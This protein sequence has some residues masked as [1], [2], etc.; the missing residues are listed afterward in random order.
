MNNYFIYHLHSPY[1]N[2]IAGMDCLTPIHLYIEQAQKWGMKALAFSEHG[3]VYNW[4]A[5]KDAVEAAGLKY[6]HAIE[7][8][9]TESIDGEKVRDNY[10]CVLIAKNWDGVKEINLLS[11]RAF[12]RA[13]GHFYYDP[14][15]TFDELFGTSDNII[16]TTA[17]IAGALGA[18]AT[19]EAREKMLSF[20]IANKHR[21]YLEVQHHNC[22][23]Q[24]DYNKT[25]LALHREFG[26]PLIA[27]TD[28]H[29]LNAEYAQARLI[30]EHGAGKS[31]PDE[32]EFDLTM[33]SYERLVESYKIQGVLSEAE[34]LEAIENTNVVADM[35]EPFALDRSY[36]YPHIY[37]DGEAVLWQKIVDGYKSHPY[38][39]KRYSWEEIG[40]RLKEEYEVMKDT[41]SVDFMLL[42]MWIRE[43][44]QKSNVSHGFGRGSV[45]GSEVAY[46]TGITDIDSIKFE[47]PF[48]RFM[49]RERVNLADIDTDYDDESKAK[50]TKFLC[51][52]HLNLPQM[53]AA[54]I[55]TFGSMA[56]KKA[57]EY[58]GKGLGYTLDEI[59]DIKAGLFDDEIQP[60][61]RQKHQELFKWVDLVNGVIVNTGIHASGIL[62][63]DRNIE[64]EVGLASASSTD[65]M[66]TQCYMKSLDAY[67]WVKF[68]ILG[69]QSLKH[70]N[71]AGEYI[72]IGH[73]T[74]DMPQFGDMNDFDVYA[75]LRED[76]T[77]VFQF[78]SDMAYAF[79][80]RLYS[81]ETLSEII[82]RL[83]D[84]DLFGLLAISNAA[85]RPAGTSYRMDIAEGKFIDYELP[86]FTEFLDPTFGRL[87]FQESITGWLQKFCGYTAGEGDVVRRA[88]A[89]KKP[90]QLAKIIPE[91]ES[92]F[93]DTMSEKYGVPKAKSNEI[94]KPFIQTIQDASSYAFNKAHSVGYSS[95]SYISAWERHYY[96]LEWCTAGLNA[97]DGD[98]EKTAK[99]TTYAKKHGIK[100]LPIKFR[101][102]RNGYSYIKEQNA[103]VKGLNSIKSIGKNTGEAL[104]QLKDG[105]YDT[106]F[107]LLVDIK[108]KCRGSVNSEH[109]EILTKLDFFSE[110]GEINA[111]LHVAD[112]FKTI[113]GTGDVKQTKN[114]KLATAEKKGIPKVL[115]EKFAE[116][117]TDKTF[118][119]VDVF[120]VMRQMESNFKRVVPKRLLKDVIEDQSNYLGYINV[121]D[122]ERFGGLV[123]VLSAVTTYSPRLSVY[124]LANG[125]IMDVKINKKLYAAQKVGKGEFMIIERWKRKPAMKLNQETGKWIA[126]NSK[127]EMWITKYIAIHGENLV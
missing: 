98:I 42:Q 93:T 19:P 92:R 7:A 25:L 111:L 112:M 62:I 109:I 88:I 44:E 15:I 40:S 64:E 30:A 101:E 43:W 104:Y 75:D 124:C 41:G 28:T 91:I 50:V 127:L 8:Y 84:I 118:M 49:S 102:S 10:H 26:I 54:Q 72:G 22:Q 83:G 23:K 122:K 107:D 60:E 5:K 65:Y 14:R 17:C 66:T 94:I 58:M 13:D 103:I 85:L 34:Y 106:F 33:L 47:L 86:Q 55:I 90:E 108:G 21:C 99:I 76:S 39:S 45:G 24:K 95:L 51:A 79:I 20:L 37:D 70:I 59:D 18:K 63:S 61:L 77:M 126:D 121:V 71:L 48:S 78:E 35:V 120:A 80:R 100:M 56:T 12:N 32:E 4:I 87:I 46:V 11:S 16:I 105:V 68:D 6:V 123:Y 113:Y 2:P 97:F 31:Y 116:K 115:L 29:S 119:G 89:K 27:G 110:F 9:L 53:R 117:K 69:L 57:I 125:N 36:K 67:N 81:K 74:P 73:P 1:S 114:I 52:D 82:K 96:P 38:A 3:N